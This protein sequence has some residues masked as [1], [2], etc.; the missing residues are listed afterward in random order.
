[1]SSAETLT[2]HAK[3]YEYADLGQVVRSLTQLWKGFTCT[4]DLRLQKTE[5]IVIN[6]LSKFS[7]LM[8]KPGV[9]NYL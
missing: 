8:G 9:H 5:G 6:R 3:R 1:M 2:Q 4:Y 7:S